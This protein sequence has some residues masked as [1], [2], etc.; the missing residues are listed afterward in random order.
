MWVALSPWGLSVQNA[1]WAAEILGRFLSALVM[2]LLAA[3]R[4]RHPL[5]PGQQALGAKWPLAYNPWFTPLVLMSP[6]VHGGGGPTV[7]QS[8]RR[9]E[10]P[11]A[12]TP[13]F[14]SPTH[15]SSAYCVCCLDSFAGE[16]SE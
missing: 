3:P 13:P 9:P 8:K 2:G 12:V 15:L 6:S 14:T 10:W 4:Y 7:Q 5:L 11:A 1:G 16:S